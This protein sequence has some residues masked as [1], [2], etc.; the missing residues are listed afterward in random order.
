MTARTGW[1]FTSIL[2]LCAA[3]AFT[4]CARSDAPGPTEIVYWTGWSGHELD[5]QQK[6]V[7]EFNRTHPHIRVRMLSV[8]GSYQKVRIAFAGGDVPDVCSAVWSDEL[9]GYAMRGALTPLDD[10]LKASGRDASEWEPGT[11]NM[12][13]YHGRTWGLVATI[14]AGFIVYNKKGFAERGLQPPPTTAAF[15]AVNRALTT[16]APNGAYKTYGMRPSGL[17]EWGYVFGGH[18]YEPASGTVTANHPRNVAA[19]RWLQSFAR[20]YDIRRMEAFESTFGSSE[21]PSGP[22]FTGKQMMWPTG[23]WAAEFIRRYAPAGFEYGAFPNPA[24]PGGREDCTTLGS[25]TVV[26]PA[27]ARNKEAAWTFLNWFTSPDVNRRFCAA[28][29]NGSPLKVVAASESI[30]SQPLLR[31]SAR[32]TGGKNAFGPPEMPIWPTYRAEISRAEDQAVHGDADPKALLDAV[33]HK[34][35]RDLDRARGEAVY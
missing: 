17:L 10:F 19:L 23:P 1:L 6:L 3:L 35:T 31:F 15:E 16:R 33:Q 8:F 11:W 22:F 7:D 26:I 21:T 18:W 9:A 12:L 30:Q 5:V 25:S 13:Q 20:D 27:A 34:I 28:I 29:A 4:G 24:P 32:L 2:V 14:N